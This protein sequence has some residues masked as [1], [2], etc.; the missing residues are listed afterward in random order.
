MVPVFIQVGR[1]VVNLESVCE[2]LIEPHAPF[3]PQGEAVPAVFVRLM[4][5]R[6][7]V[8]TGEQ[9]ARLSSFAEGLAVGNDEIRMSDQYTPA[10]RRDSAAIW[11]EV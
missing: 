2:F 4:G 6:E 7:I 1:S 9:A 10:P 5:G 11:D 8:V 3:G